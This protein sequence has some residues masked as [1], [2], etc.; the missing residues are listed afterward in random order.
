M[1]SI[2]SPS[3]PAR[4]RL[5]C[6]YQARSPPRKSLPSFK[7][8]AKLQVIIGEILG[9]GGGGGG[10]GGRGG[11]DRGRGGDRGGRGGRGGGPPM[12]G[13]GGASVNELTPPQVNKLNKILRNAKFK[14]THR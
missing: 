3:Y 12:A 4:Y 10:R 6:L 5:L 1:D 2:R 7:N 13:G 9:L 11:F 8:L 14:V